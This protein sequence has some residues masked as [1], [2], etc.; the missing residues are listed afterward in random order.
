MKNRSENQRFGCYY[1]FKTLDPL[2]KTEDLRTFAQ[3]VSCNA[4][5][6]E[7]CIP[8]SKKCLRCGKT[9]FQAIKIQSPGQL[10]A[11]TKPSRL[12][13]KTS[14][15]GYSIAGT[16]FIVPEFVHKHIFPAIYLICENVPLF[17]RQITDKYIIPMYYERI[18]PLFQ[19]LR[20]R[21]Q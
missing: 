2:D 8:Q 12:P 7:S 15:L 18:L 4:V 14:A 19:K 16:N 13:I 20:N 1:C 6:H 5:Y 21:I 17:M 3:C 11:I 9:N 10:Y